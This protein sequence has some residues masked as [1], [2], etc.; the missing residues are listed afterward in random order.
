MLF[1]SL[2]RNVETFCHKHFVVVA[3]HQPAPPLT[4]SGKCHNLPRS[5]DTVLITPSRSQFAIKPLAQNR[6]F[7]IPHM[8]STPP[9][10]G[11]RRNIAVTFG[12][13]KLEW[14]GCLMVKTF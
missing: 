4:T 9:I 8:H 6:D 11:S 13:E 12:V 7:C 5:G 3:R 2:W 10:G 14:C 1:C